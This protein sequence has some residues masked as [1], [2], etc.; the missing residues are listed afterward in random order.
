MCM[1]FLVSVVPVE[2]AAQKTLLSSRAWLAERSFPFG[3]GDHLQCLAVVKGGRLS[4]DQRLRL[5]GNC[6]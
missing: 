2:H 1:G 6:R 4:C 5:V 3:A